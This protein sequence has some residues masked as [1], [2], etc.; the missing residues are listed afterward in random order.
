MEAAPQF[1]D[2]LKQ[3]EDCKETCLSTR[4]PDEQCYEKMQHTLQRT[5]QLYEQMLDEYKR[6]YATIPNRPSPTP[7]M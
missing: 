1:G 2:A 6:K 4:N 3:L 7:R 5:Q